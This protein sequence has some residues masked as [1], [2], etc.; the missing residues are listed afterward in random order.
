MAASGATI[1]ALAAMVAATTPTGCTP[2]MR[3]FRNQ[4]PSP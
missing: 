4:A 2:W 1:S 3:R